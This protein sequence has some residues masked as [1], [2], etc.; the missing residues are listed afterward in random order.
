MNPLT[1]TKPIILGPPWKFAPQNWCLED[2]PFLLRRR[3][4]EGA[5][6]V[7][8]GVYKRKNTWTFSIKKQDH[9]PS[10]PKHGGLLYWTPTKLDS[11]RG[12]MQVNTP[13]PLGVW[14]NFW[15]EWYSKYPRWNAT[16]HIWCIRW[17]WPPHSNSDH[18]RYH[19]FSRGS[20]PKPS[21][22]TV[23]HSPFG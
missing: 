9:M 15:I 13:A 5:T 1:W 12:K 20:Q 23:T 7:S 22:A 6:L 10:G 17:V 18:Q 16:L 14:V 11:F 8:G 2:D 21:F 19:V 3:I 4:L